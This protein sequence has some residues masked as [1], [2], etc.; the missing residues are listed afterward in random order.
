MVH[1]GPIRGFI[2]VCPEC[3]TFYCNR[4]YEAVEKLENACWSYG[5][6]LDTSKPIKSIAAKGKIKIK[7]T[8]ETGMPSSLD[9]KPKK[10]PKKLKTSEK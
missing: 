10:T 1:K 2:F 7:G 3:G 5:N 4:C 6:A 8:E 9:H